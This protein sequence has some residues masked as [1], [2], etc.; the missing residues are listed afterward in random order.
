VAALPPDFPRRNIVLRVSI[1]RMEFLQISN[2]AYG[3]ST[4][5]APLIAEFGF[6]LGHDFNSGCKGLKVNRRYGYT[7]EMQ[8]GP[9]GRCWNPVPSAPQIWSIS[10]IRSRCTPNQSFSWDRKLMASKPRTDLCIHV[11][12]P[13]GGGTRLG[14]SLSGSVI[15]PS[16]TEVSNIPPFEASSRPFCTSSNPKSWRMTHRKLTGAR[17]KRRVNWVGDL[18]E[19]Y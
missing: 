6:V 8:R 17:R 11:T 18:V 2:E 19:M 14:F 12:G 3:V 7:R 16:K 9:D 13:L 10:C 4:R 1:L 5:D 15:F